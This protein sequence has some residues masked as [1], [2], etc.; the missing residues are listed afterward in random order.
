ML[1]QAVNL[2][3]LATGLV[4]DRRDPLC[5]G[6]REERPFHEVTL[7]AGAGIATR[8]DEG[9]EAQPLP[10]P[11]ML[12]ALRH[13]PSHSEG[14]LFGRGQRAGWKD[15]AGSLVGRGPA[16]AVLSP[17]LKVVEGIDDAAAN[18]AIDRA[19]AIGAVF[20]Q[21]ADG[22]AE[23]ARRIG[24]AQET[25]RQSRLGIEHDRTSGW[26]RR[27]SVTTADHGEPW[28]RIG[29]LESAGITWG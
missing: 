19:C 27:L 3:P 4:K 28:R 2:D 24:R 12:A 20:F 25:G 18:L 17:A 6:K 15:P 13:D 26:V 8:D 14:R 23:E 16:D 1:G 9:I 7:V 10:L 21:R 5:L 22:N 29:G 11:R